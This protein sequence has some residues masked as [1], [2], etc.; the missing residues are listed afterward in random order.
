LGLQGIC[1]HLASS[2][3]ALTKYTFFTFGKLFTG[4]KMNEFLK[5]Q[6]TFIYFL[7]KKKKAKRC[8]WLPPVILGTWE[9]EIGRLE[10]QGQ[11]RQIVHETSHSPPPK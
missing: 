10:D 9:T 2:L 4:Y 6:R 3:C 8:L 7:F 11:P 1:L 5:L